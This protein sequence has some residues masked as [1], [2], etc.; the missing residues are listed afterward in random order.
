[1]KPSPEKL[2]ALKEQFLFR[3][4]MRKNVLGVFLTVFITTAVVILLELSENDVFEVAKAL[5]VLVFV[6]WF[7]FFALWMLVKTAFRVF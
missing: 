2:E 6:V 7:A 5:A 1:M 3:K 4:K